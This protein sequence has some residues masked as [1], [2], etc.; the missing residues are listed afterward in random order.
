MSAEES[1]GYG[2]IDSVTHKAVITSKYN[3]SM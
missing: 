1:D 2:L 3:R